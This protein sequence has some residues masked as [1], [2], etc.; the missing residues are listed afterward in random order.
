M[1]LSLAT[2]S[3]Y[4]YSLPHTFRI[5][6]EVGFEGVEL[7][8]NPEVRLRGVDRI[9]RLATCHDLRIFSVHPPMVPVGGRRDV[10][11]PVARV[12][13]VA[14]DLGCSLMVMHSPGAE[15]RDSR[16]WTS[17]VRALE[18]AQESLLGSETRIALENQAPGRDGKTSVLSDL[19]DLRRFADEHDLAIVLDTT[20]MVGTGYSLTEGYEVLRGRLANVH[21]SD[22]RL[23]PGLLAHHV[24]DNFLKQHQLPGTG[25]VP[26][27]GFVSRLGQDDYEGLIT[28]EVSPWAL[29]VWFPERAKDYLRQTVS[30]VR[31][32]WRDGRETE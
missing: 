28:I 14:R 2:A 8:V 1:R 18:E 20:H 7:I 17:Y 9:L 12:A 6:S 19:H 3:L 32:F 22:W 26:L 31:R 15:S 27:E 13:A 25:E 23:P 5:A 21:L 10:S 11:T 16:L 24:F 29:R 30:F 4:V